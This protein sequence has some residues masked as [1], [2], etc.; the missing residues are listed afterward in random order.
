MGLI[1]ELLFPLAYAAVKWIRKHLSGDKK[2]LAW[3]SKA[4][5]F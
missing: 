2:G 1:Q 3:I 5:S 4:F